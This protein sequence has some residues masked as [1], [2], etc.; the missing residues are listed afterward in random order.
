MQNIF[1]SQFNIICTYGAAAWEASLSERSD[2][3]S[4]SQFHNHTQS[5]KMKSVWWATGRSNLADRRLTA[6][7]TSKLARNSGFGRVLFSLRADVLSPW[8]SGKRIPFPIFRERGRLQCTQASPVRRFSLRN[9]QV[10][11]DIHSE[12][13]PNWAKLAG[14]WALEKDSLLR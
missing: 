10:C 6:T 1:S 14:C 4:I 2:P 12:R 5:L 11:R 9:T 8:K 3:S 7:K 13:T